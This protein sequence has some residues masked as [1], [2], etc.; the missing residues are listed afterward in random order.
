MTATTTT[1]YTTDGWKQVATGADEFLIDCTVR[2]FIAYGQS[3]P[4]AGVIG[5]L[6]PAYS[7]QAVVLPANRSAWV[8]PATALVTGQTFSVTVTSSAM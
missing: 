7:P 2:A 3:A 1:N 6:M 4:G 8:K 5:H